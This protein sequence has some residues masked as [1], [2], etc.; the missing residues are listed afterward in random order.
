MNK[1]WYCFGV[2]YR[3]SAVSDRETA[4]VSD[5]EVSYYYREVFPK[6][7][8]SGFILN[9]CNRT[10]FFLFGENPEMVQREYEDRSGIDLE[11]KGYYLTDHRAIRHLFEVCSGVDSQILGDFEIVG[12]VR[13]AFIEA[14]KHGACDG[15]VEKVV[16]M[17]VHTSR[18]VKKETSFNSGIA[19]VS[20]ATV[21]IL[22]DELPS[23]Q[24]ASVLI[25][26]MGQIGF[27]TLLN[28]LNETGNANV[29]ITN[30][31]HKKAQ[32]I[33]ETYRVNVIDWEDW[34][35]MANN[36][37]CII[38]A[39]AVDKKILDA[40]DLAKITR[41]SLL[42]DLSMPTSLPSGTVDRRVKDID[43]VSQILE[44]SMIRRREALPQVQE[45]IAEEVIKY[46]EWKAAKLATPYME[47]VNQTIRSRC[48][49]LRMIETCNVGIRQR[50]QSWLFQEVRRNPV[51]TMNG[52]D[53]LKTVY[54]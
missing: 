21:Q 23:F 34:R 5:T 12:Q 52:E 35:S 31:T 13:K 49:V 14:K 22:K 50:I 39:V 42:M 28:V 1:V 43:Q 33:G 9:T 25:V 45:I 15:I 44:D 37:D 24:D 8:C 3:K 48:P 51:Q 20:Y 10:T 26:G 6:Y 40:E 32:K 29:S 47:D 17:A 2:S 54:R 53:L 7:R 19:S 30:R 46:M 27:R 16:N 41:P 36:F 11:S 4:S 38:S 18:R